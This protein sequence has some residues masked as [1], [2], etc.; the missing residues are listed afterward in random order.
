MSPFILFSFAMTLQFLGFIVLVKDNP[1]KVRMYYDEVFYFKTFVD[2][3]SS[4]YK[5]N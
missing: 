3:D 5:I 4:E 2:R 1:E